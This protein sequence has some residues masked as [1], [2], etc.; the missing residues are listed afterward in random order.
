MSENA[1][2]KTE[3]G[4]KR[5]SIILAKS[6]KRVDEETLARLNK[7]LP[8][9]SD[10]GNHLIKAKGK[11]LRPLITLAM[12]A[13]LNDYSISTIKLATAVEFIHTA[14]LLHDDVVDESDLRRGKKTANT[15]WGNEATVLAGDFLF[16]Q[17]FDLMVE[18]Q[19]LEALSLLAN[20]S[21]KITQGE[22]QQILISNKPDTP[23]SKYFEVIGGK[24]AE[25]FGA[26]GKSGI[27]IAGG[28]DDQQKAGYNYGFNLGIAF[29]IIDD[30]MDYSL[31]H[32][33]TGKN[34]GDDFKLGKTTLP[35]ILAWEKSNDQEKIF[36][37]RTIKQLN[38][39]D[40]DLEYA[41]NILTKYNIL[42]NCKDLAEK[43]VQNAI[44]SLNFF[45]ETE[46]KLPLLDIA[47]QSIKRTK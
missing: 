32:N 43:F 18:T 33:K 2:I 38:Q 14:T 4:T 39:N 34:M 9:I 15:L 46:F 41:Q 36:W 26:A 35:I 24:T 20:A 16:A 22:F 47:N 21:C 6:L 3:V 27:L 12:A 25:L 7:T 37:E 45:P 29:Q 28:N 8:L 10:I 23:R 11:R 30:V 13:Q 19:S 17:S 42:N 44:D 31:E 1:S 5:L 40:A